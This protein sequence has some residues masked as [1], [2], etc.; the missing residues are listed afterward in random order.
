MEMECTKCKFNFQVHI[1][2]QPVYSTTC[3]NHEWRDWEQFRYY[4]GESGFVRVCGNC[5]AAE[6][7]ENTKSETGKE[8]RDLE[9]GVQAGNLR[10]LT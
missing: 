1:E 10:G 9:P 4:S 6:L 5:F 3:K 8:C 7:K 2:V